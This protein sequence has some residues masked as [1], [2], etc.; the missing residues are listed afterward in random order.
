MVMDRQNKTLSQGAERIG[1]RVFI[2]TSVASYITLV[3]LI[4]YCLI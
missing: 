1:S 4:Y 3:L 2:V